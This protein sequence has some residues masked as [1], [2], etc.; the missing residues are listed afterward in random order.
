M[1]HYEVVICMNVIY[2]INF[3]EMA[4]FFAHFYEVNWKHLD[5]RIHYM[6]LF[7]WVY[8]LLW[9]EIVQVTIVW[10]I[11][12]N[13][14]GYALMLAILFR[15]NGKKNIAL[16]VVLIM[17]G[18]SSELLTS[19]LMRQI[20]GL[21]YMEMMNARYVMYN[22]IGGFLTNIVMATFFMITILLYTIYTKCVE[23]KKLKFIILLPIYETTLLYLLYQNSLH[24]GKI[25]ILVGL[26]L[27]LVMVSVYYLLLAYTRITIANRAEM[28]HL[29]A[30]YTQHKVELDHDHIIQERTSR[31][32]SMCAELTERL[33]QVQCC[34]ESGENSQVRA[35]LNQSYE[36][37]KEVRLEQFCENDTVNSVLNVK[38]KQA[39]KKG[40]HLCATTCIPKE[41][42][43]EAIDLCEIFCNLLDNAIEACEKVDTLNPEKEIHIKSGIRAE[44]LTIKI[45]NPMKESVKIQGKFYITTK[46]NQEEHGYGLRIVQR[47]IDRYEGMLQ[48]KIQENQ[49]VVVA[50]LKCK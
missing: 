6:V 15:E 14:S 1:N 12:L 24:M 33:E 50:S 39:E 26:F 48:T 3:Y 21:S 5:R 46:R 8:R 23:Q 41:I 38:K 35:I 42:G 32:Q 34:L 17:E 36:Q 45:Q 4:V 27:S 25:T 7:F 37:F 44:Y 40:I 43:I 28:D 18:L 20:T 19:L 9:V 47:I 11:I 22:L 49:F 30:E 13:I 2:L 10:I 29:L 16:S 31:I